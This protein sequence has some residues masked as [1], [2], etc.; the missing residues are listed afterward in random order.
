MIAERRP[1]TATKR[2]VSVDVREG[3]SFGADR[4]DASSVKGMVIAKKLQVD[5]KIKLLHM[6]LSGYHWKTTSFPT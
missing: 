1:W 4:A 5:R 6:N 2:S 3:K